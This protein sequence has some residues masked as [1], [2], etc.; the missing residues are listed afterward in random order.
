MAVHELAANA[1]QHGALSTPKGHVELTWEVR[2]VQGRRKLCLEWTEHAG[3]PVHSPQHEGF[4]STLLNKVLLIQVK[5]EVEV[6]F[7]E[8][9]LRCRIEAPLIEQRLVPEY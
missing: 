5:A 6:H 2:D 1:A 9:G 8:D 7:A 4:G 3:P